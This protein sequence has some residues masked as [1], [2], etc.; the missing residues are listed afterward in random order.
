MNLYVKPGTN[1]NPKTNIRYGFGSGNNEYLEDLREKIIAEGVDLALKEAL[2]RLRGKNR[3]EL[4]ED[5]ETTV[6]T[7][8]NRQYHAEYD[9]NDNTIAV[10]KSPWMIRC[11]LCSPCAPNAGDLENPQKLGGYWTYCSANTPGAVKARKVKPV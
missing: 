4:L 1:E 7:L 5:W 11:R 8:K 3:Q 10:F 6:Y 2:K 9:N